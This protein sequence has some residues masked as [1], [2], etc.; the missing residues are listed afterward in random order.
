MSDGRPVLVVG[1]TRGTG[2]L[3]ARLLNRKSVAVRVLARNPRRAAAALGPAIEVVAGD[4]T[5][6]SSLLP[7]LKGARD[8]LRWVGAA[9][10]IR[11]TL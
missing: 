3:I 6:E 4:I 10:A 2:L 5:K 7:A 1:G 8:M 9:S 11:T